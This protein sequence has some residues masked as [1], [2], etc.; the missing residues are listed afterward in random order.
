MIII[1]YVMI[2]LSKVAV[3]KKFVSTTKR[4][5]IYVNIRATDHQVLIVI[6]TSNVVTHVVLL[7]EIIAQLHFLIANPK[8]LYGHSE[9]L[10]FR[11][12]FYW[13]YAGK[14]LINLRRRLKERVEKNEKLIILSRGE[15]QIKIHNRLSLKKI[16][17]VLIILKTISKAKF[18]IYHHKKEKQ[19]VWKKITGLQPI[20]WEKQTNNTKKC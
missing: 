5:R 17:A 13:V 1:S 15:P 6:K 8:Y 16:L 3:M 20:S 11:H 10:Q 12:S 9:Q 2:Q 19:E 14:Q 4:T 7:E 18:M